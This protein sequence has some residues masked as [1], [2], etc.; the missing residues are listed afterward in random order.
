[1]TI[2]QMA[3]ICFATILALSITG[4]RTPIKETP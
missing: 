1:M 4:I 2:P 3:A